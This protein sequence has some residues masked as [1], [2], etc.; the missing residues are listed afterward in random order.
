MT[1]ALTSQTRAEAQAELAL[2]PA[3]AGG[4]QGLPG[5]QLLRWSAKLGFG[6]PFA[7]V[8]SLRWTCS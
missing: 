8:T 6:G 4:T 2:G 7:R 5:L 3:R 1:S